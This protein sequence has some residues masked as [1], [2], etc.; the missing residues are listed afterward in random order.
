MKELTVGP[1]NFQDQDWNAG[2]VLFFEDGEQYWENTF[3]RP[4]KVSVLFTIGNPQP[5]TGQLQANNQTL[6]LIPNIANTSSFTIQEDLIAQTLSWTHNAETGA[7]ALIADMVV[8]DGW[9]LKVTAISSDVG[10]TAVRIPV[11][12]ISVVD[13]SPGDIDYIKGELAQSSG[14]AGLLDGNVVEVGGETPISQANQPRSGRF[15]N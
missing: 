13:V 11:S 6:T 3:G 1:T 5:K 14:T 2:A 10:D 15:S 8:P 9:F 7:R 4:V 12:G